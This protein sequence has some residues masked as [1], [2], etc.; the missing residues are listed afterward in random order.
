MR[1][2]LSSLYLAFALVGP[3]LGCGDG[4]TEAGYRG[5]P[6]HGFRGQVTSSSQ[7]AEFTAPARAAVFWSPDRSTAITGRLVEQ[8]ALSVDVR[9]PGVFSINVFAPP[10]DIA[11]RDPEDPIRVGLILI[12]EDFNGDG[13][14]Q[15]GELRGGAQNQVLLW[16]ERPV[17]AADSPTGQAL[18]PGF[19]DQ[20]LPM[21]CGDQA[22]P[23]E[24]P[25]AQ[26]GAACAADADCGADGVCL[27]ADDAG[28]LPGGYCT[29][30]AS[31]GCGGAAGVLREVHVA[32]ERRLYFRACETAID[33]RVLDGYVCQDHACVRSGPAALMLD[34]AL[35]PYPLC[36]RD[37]ELE[38]G[39]VEGLEAD[40]D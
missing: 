4:L 31:A 8:G 12:Y 18:A 5:V 11:W 35:V 1:V 23:R 26:L 21:L 22:A 40:D 30:P 19:V 24:G 29:L 38:G 20:P 28:P 33:C 15:R 17:A 3:L 9:F 2:T 16:V 6:L 36:A 14:F 37:L 34:A 32:N 7:Q 39:I 10:P 13:Q 25:C 27:A